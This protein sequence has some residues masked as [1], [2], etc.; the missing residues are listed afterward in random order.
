MAKEIVNRVAQS[1]LVTLDLEA[2]FPTGKRL[3]LDLS[4]WLEGG[5][6]LREKK[7]REALKITDFSPYKDSYVALYSS[8]EAILPEW[9]PLLV[10]VYLQPYAKKVVVGSLSDLEG[11]IFEEMI[12]Q[13]D[14]TPFVDKPV[15][16]KGCSEKDIPQTAYV[17]LIQRLHPVVK[18]LFYGEACSSF[19]LYKR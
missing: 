7:F 1:S 15:I 16:V 18:S 17:S 4:Q 13:F 9:A 10:A 6:V 2:Y 11:A 14:I 19:P 8:T 12:N 3:Q 5:L